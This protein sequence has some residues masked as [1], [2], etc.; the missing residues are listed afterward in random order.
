MGEPLYHAKWIKLW[1]DGAKIQYKTDAGNWVDVIAFNSMAM[2]DIEYRVKP[3]EPWKPKDGG[4]YLFVNS[5]GNVDEKIWDS[6]K[7]DEKHYENG[8]CF[9]LQSDAEAVAE[10]VKAAMK[11]VLK[12]SA[13]NAENFQLDGKDAEIKA[14]KE[15]LETLKIRCEN[16]H[17]AK[18]QLISSHVSVDDVTLTGG[19]VALIRALRKARIKDI[20]KYAHSVLVYE[21]E[22]ETR[23][24]VSQ[25]CVAFTT[26]GLASGIGTEDAI[27]DALNKIKAER[28][29]N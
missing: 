14:L 28:E 25:L 29:T 9:H 19:E 6:S 15:E 16:L 1:A 2:H 8:N 20:P 13:P 11:G 10:Q 23:S 26:D 18:E 5:C 3:E 12:I 17:K 22:G 4:S 21:K 27:I 7:L 24:S